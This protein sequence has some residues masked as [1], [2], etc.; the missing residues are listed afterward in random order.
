L[1]ERKVSVSIATFE[2]RD[3]GTGTKLIMT[4]QGAFLDGYDDNGRR[5][6]GSLELMDKLGDFLK[7]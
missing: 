5:Q 1:D 6:Q 2:F 7:A 3:S 4:E